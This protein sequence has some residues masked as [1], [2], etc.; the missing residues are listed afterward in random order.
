VRYVFVTVEMGKGSRS[1]YQRPRDNPL[2]ATL[3]GK[4]IIEL[5]YGGQ[6]W[7]RAEVSEL[8]LAREK[9]N[10]RWKVA[11]AEVE[12]TFKIRKKPNA[13]KKIE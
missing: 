5:K 12:R 1:L 10:A 4:V 13:P 6:S 3:K 11:P 7:G 8:K 2:Q 9:N